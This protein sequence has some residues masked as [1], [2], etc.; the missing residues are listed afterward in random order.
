L[1]GRSGKTAMVLTTEVEIGMN[2]TIVSRRLRPR[3]LGNLRDIKMSVKT[4]TSAGV[5][6]TLAM[7][8]MTTTSVSIE[9]TFEMTSSR[10]CVADINDF[11]LDGGLSQDGLV[12]ALWMLRTLPTRKTKENHD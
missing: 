1:K 5:T 9:G 8:T 4:M 2:L 7:T 6:G 11:R 12:S 3:N 10:R